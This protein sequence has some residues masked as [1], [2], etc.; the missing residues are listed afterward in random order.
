MEREVGRVIRIKGNKAEVLLHSSAACGTCGARF[1]CALGSGVDRIMTVPNRFHAKVGDQVEI[2][3][4]EKTR[5][6]SALLIFFMP[7][8][9]MVIGY[10]LASDIFHSQGI[11]ILGAVLGFVISGFILWLANKM[12]VKNQRVNPHMKRLI[13]QH[14]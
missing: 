14:T 3:L 4:T 10:F 9:L 7:L 11:G 2:E 8:L 6:L 12:A 5:I 13:H 1:S